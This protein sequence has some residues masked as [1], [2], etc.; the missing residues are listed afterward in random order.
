VSAQRQEERGGR[1]H[2]SLCTTAWQ[3]Y[4]RAEQGRFAIFGTILPGVVHVRQTRTNKAIKR[5]PE[6]EGGEIPLFPTDYRNLIES[7]YSPFSSVKRTCVRAN[8]LH[9]E[10]QAPRTTPMLFEYE[11]ISP[12]SALL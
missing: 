3:A 2:G 4:D 6:R 12:A 11:Y 9:M 7:L 5:T 1:V 8:L 10:D